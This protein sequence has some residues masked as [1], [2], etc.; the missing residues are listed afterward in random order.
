MTDP[1]PEASTPRPLPTERRSASP[2]AS[3][4]GLRRAVAAAL[5]AAACGSA[6]AV[7]DAV[8]RFLAEQGLEAGSDTPA[9]APAPR[10]AVRP[11]LIEQVRSTA[12]ELVVAAMNFI[13]VP[14]RYGGNSEDEGFDC[15]GF[16]RHVF[17]L[18][19]GLVL[20]RRSN[21]QATAAGLDDV[22]RDEL[23][24]GDLV[25]FNTLRHAFSHVGIYVGGGRFIHAPRSGSEVR[26]ED[27]GSSYWARRF[28][29]ARRPHASVLRGAS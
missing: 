16:T 9:Q 23:A 5:L 21:E 26:I 25:F 28:D 12:S 17:A 11:G 4:R 10:D 22:A 6:H 27:M 29:G 8:L 18:T 7:P 19:L 15:S 2:R 20:P 14:Y 1:V 13:G 24:P 3:R